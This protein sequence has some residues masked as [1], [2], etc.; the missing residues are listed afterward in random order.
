MSKEIYLLP[1]EMSG[2]LDSQIEWL[3]M[4]RKSNDSES[5]PQD[6][7]SSVYNELTSSITLRQFGMVDF[8]AYYDSLSGD[9]FVIKDRYTG[10]HYWRCPESVSASIRDILSS[11][12]T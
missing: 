7:L 12:K 3:R 10:I 9:Y 4:A 8:L 2:I 6:L 5:F 1:I 11:P